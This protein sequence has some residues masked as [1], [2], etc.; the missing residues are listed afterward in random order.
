MADPFERIVNKQN[1]IPFKSTKVRTD[2]ASL[3]ALKVNLEYA[4]D[5]LDWLSDYWWKRLQNKP[6]YRQDAARLFNER[7]EMINELK[8]HVP[9]L[10]DIP[11]EHR[12]EGLAPEIQDRLLS[13][14]HP[15]S[16]DNPWRCKSKMARVRRRKYFERIRNQLFVHML[17]QLG[18]RRGE[19]MNLELFDID[20]DI[21][22]EATV[23]IRRSPDNERDERPDGPETKTND[24]LLAVNEPLA[25]LIDKYRENVR[26]KIKGSDAN[27]FLFVSTLDGRPLSNSTATQIFET[28]RNRHPDLSERLIHPHILRHTWNDNWWNF[29]ERHRDEFPPEIEIFYRTRLLGHKSQETAL[30]YYLNR[31]MRIKTEAASRAYQD[32]LM[33]KLKAVRAKPP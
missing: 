1:V 11:M 3:P 20:T 27:T 14:V 33:E 4:T 7:L 32:E 21:E 18:V 17:L 16:D 26:P 10:P 6:E 31:S 23:F 9:D 30:K 8:G 24:R 25:Q 5:Y 15:D 12:V 19:L 28:I 13:I 29:C 2:P 22:G